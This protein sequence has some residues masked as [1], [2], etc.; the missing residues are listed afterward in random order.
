MYDKSEED[1]IVA[2]P[3]CFEDDECPIEKINTY[4]KKVNNQLGISDLQH[5]VTY[6]TSSEADDD[7]AI[8][9]EMHHDWNNSVHIS[10][11]DKNYFDYTGGRNANPVRCILAF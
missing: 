4:L 5:K 3:E 8:T 6:W 11:A 10:F 9:V 2:H 1:H 7:N